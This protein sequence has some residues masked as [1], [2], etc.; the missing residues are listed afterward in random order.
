MSEVVHA[1]STYVNY[2]DGVREPRRSK[3]LCVGSDAV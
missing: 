2:V 3:R 1:A